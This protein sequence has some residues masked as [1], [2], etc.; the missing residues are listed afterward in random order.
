[1][2]IKEA[3]ESI[4]IEHELIRSGD[5]VLVALS[6][7]ADSVCLL[8]ILNELKGKLDFAVS[9]MHIN[10]GLREEAMNDAE[11]SKELCVRLGV[12]YYYA[13]IDVNSYADEKHLSTE[14]AGRILRYQ[15]FDKVMKKDGY[16]LLATAHHANDLA[17]TMILFLSRGTGVKGLAP[18]TYKNGNI[19]RPLLPVTKDEIVEFLESEGIRYCED[20]TNADNDYTRNYIRHEVIPRL[21]SVND[22]AVEHMAKT[23][24]IVSEAYDV[25][26]EVVDGYEKTYI[27][28]GGDGYLICDEAALLKP[29]I[30]K[31][32][33]HR[34]IVKV[35]HA[36]KDITA[37]HISGVETLMD[38]QVGRVMYLPYSL[39]ARR[40]YDGVSIRPLSCETGDRK[41]P[42]VNY[43]TRTFIREEGMQIPEKEYTKWFDYDIIKDT[44][45]IRLV[46]DDDEMTVLKSG[47][48]K[49]LKDLF[50]DLKV[51]MD[52]RK[53]YMCVAT[54][55]HVYWVIGLRMGE[56]A[57]ITDNTRVILEIDIA[58]VRR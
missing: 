45:N 17:E 40:E 1:M 4:I 30:Y 41:A 9:A 55:N 34:A 31:A 10:H 7:G 32:L 35:A 12:P 47:G 38:K 23:A 5:R 48:T 46:A 56:D 36:E 28:E 26:D 8:V 37:V 42:E 54:G 33:I 6:G 43:R 51:P 25:L 15:E 50:K 24:D 20:R 21:V 39:R 52:K 11:Y 53:D 16:D 29:Y 14:E 22:R 49:K 2:N 13:K 18:I 44:F 27:R 19:I 57:K 3:V 58:E